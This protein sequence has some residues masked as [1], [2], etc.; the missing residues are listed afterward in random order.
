MAEI[1]AMQPA[2]I[3]AVCELWLASAGLTL[4]EADS[5]AALTRFLARNPGLSFIA[6]EGE[7][8]V[9]AVL[10]GHDG[11][12]GYLHHLAIAPA[13]RRKG[14]GRALAERCLIALAAEGVVKCHLFVRVENMVARRFWSGLGWLERED[15]VIL[16]RNQSSAEN[17]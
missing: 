16:S 11:R 3:P 15:I 13:Y 5:P 1:A 6:H 12:R 7:Q 10:C 14:I 2:Y 4:R 9:G 8:I 17:A